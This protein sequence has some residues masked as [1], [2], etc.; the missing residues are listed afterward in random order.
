MNVTRDGGKNWANV[1]PP[2]LG[3]LTRISLVEA[4]PHDPATA[5]VA[6]NRYQDADRGLYVYK[7]A[8]LGRTWT[9]IVNGIAPGDFARSI[10]EDVV[11]RDLLYLGT[12]HGLYVSFD[13]GSRWQPF[14]LNLPVTPVH[15]IAVEKNDLVIA[16][17]GRGF[18]VLDN[19]EPLRELRSETTQT[20]AY[21]FKPADA[22][23]GVTRANIDYY[24]ANPAADLKLEIFDASGSVV[25][26]FAAGAPE[27]RAASGD[28]ESPPPPARSV[29][30]QRGLNRF[31]WD[32]RATPSHDFPGLIMY[33]ASVAGPFVPPDRYTVKLTA[34]GQDAH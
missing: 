15:D 16:T 8:N 30:S 31:V 17:H 24:L 23:R 13:G 27:S 11:R 6:A 32:M 22:T 26:A 21:L 3:P 7:T 29:P 28:D 14:R 33:Q 1:T 20:A 34:G 12:E 2:D 9:K 19:I 5:Y 18:Y 25:R 10:R 4:S